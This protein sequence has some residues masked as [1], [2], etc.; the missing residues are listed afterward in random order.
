MPRPL[1]RT[2]ETGTYTVYSGCSVASRLAITVA[3][4]SGRGDASSLP[5][6]GGGAPSGEA[7]FACLLSLCRYVSATERACGHTSTTE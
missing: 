2:R 6:R 1:Y 5:L 7:A 3:A 4:G